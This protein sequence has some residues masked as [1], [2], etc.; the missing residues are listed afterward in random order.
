MRLRI[1]SEMRRV[2]KVKSSASITKTA[3]VKLAISVAF[4]FKAPSVLITQMWSDK[5]SPL[6]NGFKGEVGEVIFQKLCQ[7]T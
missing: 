6:L 3:E 5:V 1:L 7:L 4:G 2:T